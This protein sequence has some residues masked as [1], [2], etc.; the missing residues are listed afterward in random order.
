MKD[1]TKNG[2]LAGRGYQSKEV[3]VLAAFAFSVLFI[4]VT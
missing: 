2:E 4:L 3:F 1:S